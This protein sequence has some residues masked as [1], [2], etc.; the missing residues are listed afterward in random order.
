MI[1]GT[2]KLWD[3][4]LVPGIFKSYMEVMSCLCIGLQSL[5]AFLG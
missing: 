2:F 4:Y 1:E 5:G 3:H